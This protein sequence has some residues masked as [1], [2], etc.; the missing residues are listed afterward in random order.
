[1]T[2]KKDRFIMNHEINEWTDLTPHEKK[3]RLYRD[4]VRLLDEFLERGAISRAQY[5]K[6]YHDLTM[7][8]G[9]NTE[10]TA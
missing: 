10:E 2:S 8:M 1:M 6:S 9:M 7:K 5:E 3:E 4:Q